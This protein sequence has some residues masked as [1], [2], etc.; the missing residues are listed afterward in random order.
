MEKVYLVWE[1][2]TICTYDVDD[3]EENVLVGVY[4]SE[5]T[6]NEVCKES[7]RDLFVEECPIRY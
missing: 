6:A 7:G 5:E 3:Y 4:A 2:H 1:K